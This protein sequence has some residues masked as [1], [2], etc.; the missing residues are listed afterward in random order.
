M[1]V[2]ILPPL[3]RVD[4]L[5]DKKPSASLVPNN[6]TGICHVAT[7]IMSVELV[8]RSTLS[9]SDGDLAVDEKS[10]LLA[11]TYAL[12]IKPISFSAVT[13]IKTVPRLIIVKNSGCHKRIRRNLDN[14]VSTATWT[15]G[16]VPGYCH[17]G[18][19]QGR[20]K[21]MDLT[22]LPGVKIISLYVRWACTSGGKWSTLP[23]S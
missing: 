16:P 11:T 13:G 14:F 18:N 2:K 20:Q 7:Q 12:R 3:S 17:S 22:G 15:S 6:K 5:I 4:L 9:R 8:R 21:P 10:Q 19:S 1:Q 23:W